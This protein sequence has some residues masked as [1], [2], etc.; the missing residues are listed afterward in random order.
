MSDGDSNFVLTN[1]ADLATGGSPSMERKTA[2]S[3]PFNVGVFPKSDAA[4]P[5]EDTGVVPNFTAAYNY[6]A[7]EEDELTL[8]KGC[9]SVVACACNVCGAV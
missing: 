7:Q 3:N 6:E 4:L 1:G 9:G 2:R 8:N 5:M